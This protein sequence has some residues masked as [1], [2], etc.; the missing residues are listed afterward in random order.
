MTPF[1]EIINQEREGEIRHHNNKLHYLPTYLQHHL[2]NYYRKKNTKKAPMEGASIYNLIESL[3]Y[4]RPERIKGIQLKESEESALTR[5][6]SKV[7]S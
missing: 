3:I 4:A 6:V 7:V 2:K 1:P 5:K